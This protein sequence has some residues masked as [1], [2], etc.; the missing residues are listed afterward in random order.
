MIYLY[1]MTDVG[2][3]FIVFRMAI[4]IGIYYSYVTI[5]FVESRY[6]PILP[7]LHRFF[8]NSFKKKVYRA[9]KKWSSIKKINVGIDR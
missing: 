6:L 9:L 7:T 3:T 8:F 4:Y 5:K 2:N 1:M